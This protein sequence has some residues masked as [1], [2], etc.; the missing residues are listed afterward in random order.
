[1]TVS[2]QCKCGGVTCS[3]SSE[4]LTDWGLFALSLLSTV[5][6]FAFNG[7]AG[8]GALNGVGIG[9]VSDAHSNYIV[10]DGWAFSIWGAIYSLVALLI[11]AQFISLV[12]PVNALPPGGWLRALVGVKKELVV[13]KVVPLFV[14]SN[15]C[16]ICWIV[17]FV[18]NTTATIAISTVLIFSLL[19]ILVAIY[20]RT[21]AWRALHTQ[22]DSLL[23]VLVID[24]LFGMYCGWLTVACVVA[25]AVFFVTI[26]WN[27]EPWNGPGWACVMLV[28]AALIEGA[29]L[30]TRRDPVFAA[31]FA[32]AT[33]AIA[34]KHASESVAVLIIAALCSGVFGVAAIAVAVAHCV[35]WCRRRNGSAVSEGLLGA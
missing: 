1:M 32:W 20:L 6:V 33:A 10:P 4:A 23:E 26:G 5:A 11:V 21:S 29:N 34:M 18:L 3:V 13:R 15:L 17:F 31:V 2:N 16:N 30:A 8:S 35:V 14:A 9:D 12:V 19:A 27:G 24:V 28:V 25:G 7:L 22:R